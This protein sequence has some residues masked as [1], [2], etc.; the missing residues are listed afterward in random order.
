[1]K[2]TLTLSN[3]KKECES[4]SPQKILFDTESQTW[5]S[6][7]DTMR[8]GFAFNSVNVFF[9]PN[10]VSLSSDSNYISFGRVKYITEDD[11]SAVGKAFTLVCDGKDENSDMS[12]KI[13]LM[14]C[15]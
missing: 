1:M 15:V 5:K 9:N 10:A 3:F 6:P 7:Y 2:K 4:I 8:M 14:N 13:L 11:E 12:Y